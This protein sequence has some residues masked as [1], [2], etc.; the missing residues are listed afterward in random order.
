MRACHTATAVSATFD[1]PNLVSCAGLVPVLRLASRAGLYAAAQQRVGLPASAGSAGANPGSK[2][3]SIVAGMVAGGDSID[4]LDVIRHGALPELFGGIR[5]PSTLG[6]FLRGFTWGNVRQL[7]AVARE[8]LIGLARNAPLLPGADQYALLDVDSTINRV[9]G[10]AKQGADYGYTRVRGLHPLL[11]TV[12]TPIAAAVIVGTRLRRGSAGSA[13]GAASFVAEAITTAR[14]AGATGVLLAR[15]DSAFDN[16]AVV[17][18]CIRAGV[19]FSITT[20][21]TRPVRAAIEAIDPAG[22]VPIAYPHAIYDEASGQWISDAEIAETTYIAFRSR[23]KSEQI[24]LRLIVRRVK[25]K[26]IVPGQGELF[27]AWRYHAFITDST[28]QLVAA[29]KQHRQHAII[30]QVNADLKDSAMAHMPSGSFAANAAWLALAAIAHNLTRAAG[31]LAS[32]FHAKARTGTV[33]RHLITVPARIA[34][35]S[36][37]ITLRLPLNWPHRDTFSDLFTATHGPPH[38]T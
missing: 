32:L 8:T 16:H 9:Y 36:R 2:I 34:R 6:T 27:T 20:K 23:R 12:S 14:A 15:M 38:T 4:D 17:S 5:A 3:T 29:E 30:E 25:D 7:D 33:R 22:W 26:N 19:R 11:A 10:Y 18:T 13:R 35:R 21:Q 37:R 28:L 1:E 31:C 24:T